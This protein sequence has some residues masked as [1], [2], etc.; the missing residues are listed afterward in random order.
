MGQTATS[1]IHYRWKMRQEFD[2]RITS[3]VYTQLPM[4]HYTHANEI[5]LTDLYTQKQGRPQRFFYVS[6]LTLVY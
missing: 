1:L 3:C 2:K 5:E 4:M 6:P